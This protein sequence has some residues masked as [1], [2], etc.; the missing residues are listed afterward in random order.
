MAGKHH[1]TDPNIAKRVQ[2]I[3]SLKLRYG[4]TAPRIYEELANNRELW[5]PRTG[6]PWS[7]QTI[8]FDLQKLKR[9]WREE[10]AKN[11]DDHM[12]QQLLS[13]REA[14]QAAW[15]QH[16]VGNVLRAL[17]QEA[18]LLGL[19]TPQK[20]DLADALRE[21]GQGLTSLLKDTYDTRRSETP[22]L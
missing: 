7:V 3:S 16:D 19:D 14:R 9:Q 10:A 6:K 4:W 2:V 13:I 21:M 18:D 15:G 12:S 22:E 20:S 11:F 5:N 1:D 17:K 8:R